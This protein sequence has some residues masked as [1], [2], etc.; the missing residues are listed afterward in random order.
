MGCLL[1][2][3]HPN[4]FD[5]ISNHGGVYVQKQHKSK[6][7]NKNE[8]LVAYICLIPSIIGLIFLTYVP[9]VAVFGLSLTKWEG[10]GAY[11]NETSHILY[12]MITKYEVEQLKEIIHR[13]DPHAFIIMNEG[14]MVV[15]N[16]E[17][18]L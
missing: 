12:I 10:V 4:L 11:T 3:R 7:M 2:G 15:G 6:K 17:K 8:V 18:R 9:L 1:K 13:V 5:I 16:F 14:S